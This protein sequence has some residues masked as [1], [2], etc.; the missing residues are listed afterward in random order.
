LSIDQ[1]SCRITLKD[2][3]LGAGGGDKEH[4]DNMTQLLLTYPSP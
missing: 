3:W 4:A 2:P 1:K